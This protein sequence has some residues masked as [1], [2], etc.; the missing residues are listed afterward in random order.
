MRLQAWW[1]LRRTPAIHRP[2]S[3]RLARG[4][5]VRL[6]P[7]V[8][9]TSSAGVPSF[10]IAGHVVDAQR[11]RPVPDCR[12][13]WMPASGAKNE[14]VRTDRQGEF[15]LQW[16]KSGPTQATVHLT[17]PGYRDETIPVTLPHTGGWH[18]ATIRLTPLRALAQAAFQ[19]EIQAHSQTWRLGIH[20]PRWVSEQIAALRPDLHAPVAR[21]IHPYERLAFGPKDAESHPVHRAFFEQL[22]RLHQARR[23]GSTP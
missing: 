19:Q 5:L 18:R 6:P 20:S 4:P 21:V 9:R 16:T 23:D 11:D 17:C 8:D 3:D 7:A 22:E 10:V 2:R 15:R 14:A 12:L 1:R 13:E